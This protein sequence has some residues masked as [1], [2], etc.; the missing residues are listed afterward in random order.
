MLAL[1]WG[2]GRQHAVWDVYTEGRNDTW[3]QVL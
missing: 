2:L 1:V 3:V